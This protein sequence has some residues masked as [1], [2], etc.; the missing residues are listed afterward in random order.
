M[1]DGTAAE[2]AGWLFVR[3]SDVPEPLRDRAVAMSMVPLYPGELT[4]LLDPARR[5][6]APPDERTARLI[7]LVAQGLPKRQVARELQ[8]PDRTLDRR[9]QQLRVRFGAA[10][11]PELAA[12]LVQRGF[13]E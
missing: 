6:P 3:S 10:T 1:V 8:M 13:G 2:S 4:A 9:L 5:A 12:L 7:A 11:Y